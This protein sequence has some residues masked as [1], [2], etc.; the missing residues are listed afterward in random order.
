[1]GRDRNAEGRPEQRRP[2]DRTGRPLPYGITGVATTEL[3]DPETVTDA[4]ELGERLWNESRYFEA[5]ECLEL[6]W[7]AVDADAA[8][9][10][11]GVIQIAVAAVHL[12]RGNPSGARRL[13][14]RA[15]DKLARAPRDTHG[16]DVAYAKQVC[17][18]AIDA[19]DA[20]ESVVPPSFPCLPEGVHLPQAI[21]TL[22]PD[23]ARD[24]RA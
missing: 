8:P 6:V 17:K 12:Q 1:M 24:A 5:H 18:R 14:G 7:H 3:H 11:Q 10:W 19:I 23:A 20:G 9:M 4:V 15:A 21:A 2:R 13:F 22:P 16:L